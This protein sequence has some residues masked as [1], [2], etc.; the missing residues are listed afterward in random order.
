MHGLQY[1]ASKNYPNFMKLPVEGRM[2]QA[3]NEI[4]VS[5]SLIWELEKDGERTRQSVQLGDQTYKLPAI[6]TTPVR[7]RSTRKNKQQK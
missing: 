2:P 3:S 4:A 5:R 1:L 7:K 6:R